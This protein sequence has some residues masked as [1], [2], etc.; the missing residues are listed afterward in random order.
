M[1][2]HCVVYYRVRECSRRGIFDDIL[3]GLLYHVGIIVVDGSRSDTNL[4]MI[5]RLSFLSSPVLY[6]YM[7]VTSVHLFKLFM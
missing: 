2:V 4:V 1:H 7:F 5:L 3:L 6:M